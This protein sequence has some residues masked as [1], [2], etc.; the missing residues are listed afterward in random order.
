MLLYSRNRLR[1][2]SRPDL[3]SSLCYFTRRVHL[4]RLAHLPHAVPMDGHRPFIVTWESPTGRLIGYV[5]ILLFFSGGTF[6]TFGT[7][8][9]PRSAGRPF[10][11]SVD[12][13]VPN[14]YTCPGCHQ[15]NIGYMQRP[16]LVGKCFCCNKRMGTS[17]TFGA[18]ATC[19][20]AGLSTFV[21][22]SQ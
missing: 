6:G 18:Y 20:S 22:V 16:P 21:S 10:S 15:K 9:M 11:A 4:Q 7:F 19:C 17:D 1:Q 5:D 12:C 8:A 3:R 2:R 14:G 13:L